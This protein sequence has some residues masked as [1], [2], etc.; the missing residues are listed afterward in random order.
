[1]KTRK[2]FSALILFFFSTITHA[3]F[4][5]DA[6]RF[7]S[8][9][10]N[11]GARALGM[12]NAYIGVADD[13]S[14]TRWNPAG[15]AQLRRLEF[16]GG[17]TNNSYNNAAAFRGVST[18]GKNSST[19]LNDIGFVFPY[20]TTQGSLVFAFGYNRAADFTSALSFN[21][22]N[23][24]S[25][26]IPSLYQGDAKYDVPFNV[27]LENT[28][29]YTLIQGNVNQNGD[30]RES[31][32]TG[33]WIFSGALDIE[34]DVSFGITLNVI[35]GSY[36][37]DRNYVEEDTKNIYNNTQTNLPADSSYLRFNKFYYDSNVKS[38][39]SGAN[40]T[41][42]LMYRMEDLARIG[43]IV[44][45][46]STITVKESYHDEGQSIF[47]GGYKP[48]TTKY[49]YDATVDYGVI[50]PWTFGFGISVTPIVGVLISAD[51][52]YTDW[53]QVAWTDNKDLERDN[54]G[55]KK[56]LRA[57]TNVRGG[58]EFQ[59]PKTDV[60]VRGGFIYNPSTF[61]NDPSSFDKKTYTAGAG[62][63][64]QRNVL[65]DVAAAFGSFK[66]FHNNYGSASAN[67]SRTDET[68]ST[69]VVN[70]TISYRF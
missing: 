60:S 4:I 13:Y 33:H 27:F 70:F 63:L 22:F 54:A 59:I 68:I 30:V 20:P 46:P 10:N 64:L 31:G 34:K 43:L 16:S 55:F 5:E 51:V 28:K 8:T 29:G 44:K 48:G 56:Y 57:T 12:G 39:L 67:L 36:T 38:E 32:G 21:G 7:S 53:T 62:I 9:G 61:K 58:A 50:T 45:T 41:L 23:E 37:F 47:D 26:I 69:T 25:S 40:F 52:E 19:V 35:G 42:G 17:I 65:L 3:Q 66:T 24:G 2:L 6:L 14:A 49:G 1:M 15:L 11:V 18:D